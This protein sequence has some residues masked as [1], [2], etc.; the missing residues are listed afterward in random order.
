MPRREIVS[1]CFR[2]FPGTNRHLREVSRT[3][4]LSRHLVVSSSDVSSIEITFLRDEVITLAPRCVIFG[5]WHA[6]YEPLVEAARAAGAEIAV[7]WTSSVVQTDFS[8]ET[9]ILATLLGDRRVARFFA[10]SA[11][12]VGPLATAGRPSHFLPQPFSI[13]AKP[14]AGVRANGVVPNI[15]F[16][17]APNE[18]RR[19]NAL[20]SII[21]LAGLDVPYVLHVNGLGERAE[22]RTFLEVLRI[23]HHDHG[24]MDEDDYARALDEIDVGMQVSLADSFNY[25]VAEHFARAIPVLVS[26]SVPCAHGLPDEVSRLLVVAE[27]DNP[28]EMRAKLRVLLLDP[29]VRRAAGVAA[30]QHIEHLSRRHLQTA[31]RALLA[32]L[33]EE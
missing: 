13:V 9:S 31:R 22:Y 5:G 33:G 2:G 17:C 28:A 4:A 27:P 10:A 23:P 16:F 3:T 20:A 11:E 1:L 26:R 7:L 32:A 12:M 8:G 25:V 15:S 14:V 29:E 18:Y 21:S 6:V 30:R 24:W 19:K